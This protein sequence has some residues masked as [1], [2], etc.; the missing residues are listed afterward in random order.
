MMTSEIV[1]AI[2]YAARYL[3]MREDLLD[4][5]RC[6]EIVPPLLLNESVL[7]SYHLGRITFYG[8]PIHE[9]VFHEMVHMWQDERGEPLDIAYSQIKTFGDYYRLPYEIEARDLAAK[10]MKAYLPMGYLRSGPSLFGYGL[11]SDH[12]YC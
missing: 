6:W 2:R 8:E 12:V 11:K 5:W 9:T 7:G 3:G 1:M 10:M 4:A